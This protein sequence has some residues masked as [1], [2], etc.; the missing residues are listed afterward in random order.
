MR[1]QMD[2]SMTIS[3]SPA[4]CAER[5]GLSWGIMSR[6]SLDASSGASWSVGCKELRGT[7][8]GDSMAAHLLHANLYVSRPSS[9]F[10]CCSPRL[11]GSL[12]ARNLYS[13]D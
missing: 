11:Q 13:S 8:V 9:R 4:P 7:V 1:P 10:P 6:L 3:S 5:D 2:Q 12:P